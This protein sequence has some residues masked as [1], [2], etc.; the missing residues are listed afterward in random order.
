MLTPLVIHIDLK[1]KRI[2]AE[3]KIAS[4]WKLARIVLWTIDRTFG[5][6]ENMS[7][8]PGN[9]PLRTKHQGIW[10]RNKR[11]LPSFNHYKSRTKTFTKE[12]CHLDTGKHLQKQ[13]TN[14]ITSVVF[15]LTKQNHNINNPTGYHERIS[16]QH[17]KS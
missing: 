1:G 2:T 11:L 9:K 7:L 10:N 3:M 14:T 13:K 8:I 17:Y 4:R 15:K 5:G 12:E 16:K 6:L